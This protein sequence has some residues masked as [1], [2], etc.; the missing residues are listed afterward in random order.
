[1]FPCAIAHEPC[2]A[3]RQDVQVSNKC[4][5]L[6]NCNCCTLLHTGALN[7]V[8]DTNAPISQKGIA[9]IHNNRNNNNNSTLFHLSLLHTASSPK[10]N[11][12][13]AREEYPSEP[14][15][16]FLLDVER[17][18]DYDPLEH[19]LDLSVSFQGQVTDTCV[20]FSFPLLLV[21]AD[22]A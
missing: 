1:M 15:R 9:C 17:V 11:S 6:A 14:D 5:L 7:L 16:S 10:N 20:R 21:P 19:I 3:A 12:M 22:A 4:H 18:A 2:H 8:I 13:F